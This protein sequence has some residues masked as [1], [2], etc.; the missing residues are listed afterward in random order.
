MKVEEALAD[1]MAANVAE[2][3]A[4]PTMGAG[5]RRRHRA[6]V[7]RFR[8]A[9]AALA[10]AVLAAGVPVYLAAT[11]GPESAGVAN[12]T[13]TVR[14]VTKVTVPDVTN[15]TLA[16]AQAALQAVGLVGE[17]A[18]G[19]EGVF[20][21]EPKP[22]EEV[23]T[24]STVR[25]FL[26][27]KLPNALGDLGDGRTFGGITLGYLPEGL[28]WGKWSNKWSTEKAY[29]GG[30][31]YTTTFDTPGAPS[32]HYDIQ[33]YVHEGK[34]STK[35][36][37][38]LERDGVEIVEFG[39]ERAYLANVGEGGEF[40]QLGAQEGSEPATPTL[41]L[42]L[43]DDLAVEVAM[44]PDRAERLGTEAVAAELKKIA[45]GVRAAK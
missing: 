40:G 26:V 13:S 21:Q 10:T 37:N 15:K 34:A 9:G 24:G 18:T 20:G 27:E 35:V 1:A 4:P 16:E 29:G 3:K 39:D 7:I 17:K 28:V 19:Y 6:H 44:S 38:D 14:V 32:G 45:E 2:V 30:M 12:G 41:G 8:T 33:V 23:E 25:L 31:V 22:G 43:T 36:E 5:V 11:S 42:K